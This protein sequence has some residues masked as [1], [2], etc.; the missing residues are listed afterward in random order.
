MELKD[1]VAQYKNPELCAK[2]DN[3]IPASELNYPFVFMVDSQDIEALCDTFTF[4][5]LQD[6][7]AALVTVIDG[8]YG[9]VYISE[10][11][12]PYKASAVYHPLD[13]YIEA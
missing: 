8:D 5:P 6:I 10:S 11:S 12:H 4:L 1:Y 3:N 13:Y 9:E 7:T 2:W